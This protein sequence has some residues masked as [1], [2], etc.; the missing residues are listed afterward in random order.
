MF[1]CAAPVND[2]PNNTGLRNLPPIK[3][4]N[5]YYSYAAQPPW[6]NLYGG[7]L[8]AGPRYVYDASNPSP[9][10][11]PEWFNGRRFLLEFTSNFIASLRFGSDL[12]TPEDVQLFQPSWEFGAP[13]DARFGPDGSLYLLEYGSNSFSSTKL[14]PALSR[15]DYVAGNRTPLAR[16]KATPENGPTPL[17]VEFDASASSDPDGDAVTYAWDFD[18]D[19]T[20]DSTAVKVTHRFAD[21]G[22]LHAAADGHRRQRRLVGVQPHGHGRQHGAQGRVRRARSTGRS[23]SSTSR[24]RSRSR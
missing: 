13:F 7:G 1:D 24:S 2:S 5:L 9:T 12:K 10:K 8:H 17:D 3:P 6:P 20:T 18:R 14:S 4:A 21:V 23:T 15:I 22:Q 16:A 11:F 19:G